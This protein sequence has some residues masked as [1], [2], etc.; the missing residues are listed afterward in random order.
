[1]FDLYRGQIRE[2]CS[3]GDALTI[4]CCVF[5]GCLP[6]FEMPVKIII[7]ACF[8]HI[9]WKIYIYIYSSTKIETL[10]FPLHFEERNQFRF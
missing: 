5:S 2:E 4:L 3:T 9:K 1:M 7:L 6:V 10:N 8:L